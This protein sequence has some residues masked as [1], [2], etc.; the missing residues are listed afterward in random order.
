[1]YQSINMKPVVIR[2]TYF[3]QCPVEGCKTQHEI[4][5]VIDQM[6]GQSEQPQLWNY[7]SDNLSCQNHEL[8]FVGQVRVNGAEVSVTGEWI[9][10]PKKDVRC[11][12]VVILKS[13][14]A[15][16]ADPIHVV[17]INRYVRK[18]PEANYDPH[19]HLYYHYDEG[20]C[21]TNWLRGIEAIIHKEDADP[22]GVFEAYKI[23]DEEQFYKLT[24]HTI[25]QLDDGEIDRNDV[26]M[27]MAQLAP[28]LFPSFP[29]VP[30]VLPAVTH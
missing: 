8:T 3:I 7:K 19:D 21:P 26:S 16:G 18:Y 5:H 30:P 12:V 10:L 22:H 20:T 14:N 23:L 28:E 9:P 11:K 17:H 24:G 29:I 25:D 15:N 27:V 4:T 13:S 6:Q 1:M 2:S